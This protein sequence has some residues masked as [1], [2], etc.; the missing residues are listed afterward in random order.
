M[1]KLEWA[2]LLSDEVVERSFEGGTACALCDTTLD[3]VLRERRECVLACGVFDG[4]H[5]GHRGLLSAA[6][7]QAIERGVPCVVVTFDPDPSEVVGHEPIVRARLLRSEDRVAGLL[8]L[9]ADVVV[10]F[11]FTD[12]FA[13]LAPDEFL[14]DQLLVRTN[15]TLVHVGTNFRY[16]HAGTGDV[17]HLRHAGEDLG[18]DVIVHD[19]ETVGGSVVS[20]TRIRSLLLNERLEEANDLLGRCH[21]V[22]GT[23][24]RGRGEGTGFGFPTANVWCDPADCL[25]AEGVYACYVICGDRAWPAAANVG[26]PPTFD[27][28]ERLFVEA[29]LLGFEGDLYG[30]HVVVSFVAWLRPSRVFGSLDELT[31]VVLGNINWVRRNLGEGEVR[32]G[33]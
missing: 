28:S 3:A 19:L 8:A 7:Q 13:A 9:G 24:E 25:P 14:R 17:E 15:P 10:S 18:F 16:G 1:T 4:L 21:Y 20:S 2:P 30:R 33:A 23:V 22:H 6:S 26:A 29:N 31:T 12:S 11:A 5:V 32:V 27:S